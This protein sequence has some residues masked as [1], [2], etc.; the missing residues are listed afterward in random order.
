MMFTYKKFQNNPKIGYLNRKKKTRS[1]KQIAARYNVLKY[2]RII[3]VDIFLILRL[4]KYENI[5][6]TTVL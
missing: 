5:Q 2:A 1:K 6:Y 3:F 4:V